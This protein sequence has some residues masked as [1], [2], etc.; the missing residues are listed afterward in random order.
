MIE[1][2]LRQ[3]VELGVAELDA[4][5]AGPLRALAGKGDGRPLLNQ[6]G[7]PRLGHRRVVVNRFIRRRLL[8]VLPQHVGGGGQPHHVLVEDG[9][10]D[11]EVQE[12][13]ALEPP[14]P[15]ELGVV[16]RDHDGRWAI[17]E[18]AAQPRDLVHAVVEEVS[19]VLG[20]ALPRGVRF[21]FAVRYDLMSY[22]NPAP[23]M[24]AATE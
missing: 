23:D 9:L 11:E 15:E 3:A 5:A 14:V 20:G 8:R 13:R 2:A 6:G 19:G 4:A 12:P 22:R 10:A 7:R 1:A 17:G 16:G 18:L 21:A 24:Q